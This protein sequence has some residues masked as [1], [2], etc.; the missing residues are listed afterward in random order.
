MGGTGY[1][2]LIS[3][4]GTLVEEVRGALDASLEVHP[5]AIVKTADRVSAEILAG[6]AFVL[7]HVD[8]GGFSGPVGRLLW[9]NSTMRRPIPVLAL[10]DV[11]EARQALAFF[12]MGVTDVLSRPHHLDRLGA[13][14]TASGR[15]SPGHW[16]SDRAAALAVPQP[17]WSIASQAS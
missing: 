8:G 17:Y 15:R 11:Y 12:R 3:Q 14:V 5:L 6:V 2:L 4:D 1:V 7:I 13:L 16:T 9:L 10:V